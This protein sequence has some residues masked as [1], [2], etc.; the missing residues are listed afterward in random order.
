MTSRRL[1]VSVATLD[2]EETFISRASTRLES[3]VQMISSHF[4]GKSQSLS[5]MN[6]PC[7]VTLAPDTIHGLRRERGSGDS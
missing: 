7:L 2:V 6:E 5:N 4:S 3:G 1:V